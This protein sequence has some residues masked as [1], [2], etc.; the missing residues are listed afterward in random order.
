MSNESISKIL[1][2][3][4]TLCL[5][6]SVIVSTAAVGLRPLQ[7]RNRQ[8]E[9]QRSILEVA[10]LNAPEASLQESFRQIEPRVVELSTGRF[11]DLDAMDFEAVRNE[12]RALGKR[13]DI[14]NIGWLPKF[15]KIY[16]VRN[17]GGIDK[18]ILP[19][20][21]YGLWSTLYGFLALEKDGRT[22]SKLRF[23]K[24]AETPGLGGE[25]DNPKWR[26]L[27]R[28]KLLYDDRGEVRLSVVKGRAD[29]QSA[30]AAYRVD[31]LAGAT[32]TS[33]GVSRMIE[34]WAGDLGYRPF[35]EK[36]KAGELS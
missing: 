19:V 3:T 13:E 12:G 1:L 34:F 33:R 32:L 26:R 27:W 30:E 22:V 20:H 17:A 10:G 9:L 29:E 36:I 35:L 24:H 21:G 16:L 15:A 14:A 23:Y 6:C 18:I 31:G 5:V 25:V 28:G 11:M 8:V 4:V 7:E 2:V